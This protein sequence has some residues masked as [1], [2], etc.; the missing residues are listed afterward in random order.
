MRWPTQSW[1]FKM[2]PRENKNS[3]SHP[4]TMKIER[5]IV[6]KL[7]LQ[8]Y[9]KASA[10]VAELIANSYDADA[11]D[12]VVKIPLGKALAVHKGGVLEQKGYFIEVEDNGHGMT[13]EEARE[14]YLKVGIDRR[15]NPRHGSTSREKKRDVMGH[16]GIGKLAPFGICHTIEV[17]SAG[18]EKTRKGYRVAHF[19]LD[20]D[21]IIGHTDSKSDEHYHPLPLSDDETFDQK[22]GTRV[23]LKNFNAKRV[24]DDK[25]FHRQLAARFGLELPDFRISVMDVKEDN[26][27]PAFQ[28][29]KLH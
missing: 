6:D 29:G 20:Y 16:K 1:R 25:T 4:Y 19:E 8:M 5:T 23:I 17:R 7:G 27:V 2:S 14:F 13:P 3:A 22:R 26:P 24:P 12:V 18:G 15:K 21:E 28:V 11:E 9:D 10:V